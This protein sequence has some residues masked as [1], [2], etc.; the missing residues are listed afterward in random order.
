MKHNNNN[1]NNNNNNKAVHTD[2]EVTANRPDLIIK[3]KKEKT[4]TLIDCY[5]D[6]S[7][8][9]APLQSW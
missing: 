5:Q 4:C 3:N 1:N 6:W 9:I 7:G 8:A 2:R